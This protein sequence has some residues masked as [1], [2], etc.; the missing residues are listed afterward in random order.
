MTRL[1]P[2]L[3]LLTSCASWPRGFLFIDTKYPVEFTTGCGLQVL[4]SLDG[5]PPLPAEWTPAA[6]RAVEARALTAFRTTPDVRFADGCTRL[7]GWD[8]MVVDSK[9]LF[10]MGGSLAGGDTDCHA[11]RIFVGN[12]APDLG[13]LA[14]EL[15]HAI[16]NCQPVDDGKTYLDVHYLWEPIY[17]ALRAAG[18]PE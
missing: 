8:V 2:L 9:N 18:L 5:N 12:S 3:L 17:A 4:G 15:G 1:L 16:Q 11:H 13:R 10:D 7:R 6:V 14:H